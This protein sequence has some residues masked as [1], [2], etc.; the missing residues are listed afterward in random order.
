MSDQSEN[1]QKREYQKGEPLTKAEYNHKYEAIKSRT[2]KLV[3]V[4]VPYEIADDFKKMCKIKGIT[5]Q[6]AISLAMLDF[7]KKS[8]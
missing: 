6:K 4:Y 8:N 3:R 1:K 5:Q 2:H 7:F